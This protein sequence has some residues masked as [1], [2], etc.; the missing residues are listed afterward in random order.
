VYKRIRPLLFAVPP[1]TAH[2]TGL[3][4]ARL[5]GPTR[6][7]I[8]ASLRYDAS[9]LSQYIWGL[10]FSNPVGLAAGLD[11][12]AVAVPYWAA[13]GFGLIEIGSVS[14]RSWKGNPRPRLFRLPADRAL[15]NRM[16]LNNQGAT[17]VAGRL[18]KLPKG[19]P[20][21]GA[22]IVKTPDPTVLGD[23][24]IED[25]AESLK[26][27][28][29]TAN[30]V[31]I[32]VSCPNTLEGKTFE[33]PQALDALLATLVK[34]R[35]ETRR[36]LPLLVKLSPPVSTKFVFDSLI[37]EIVAVCMQHGIDGFVASN[38]SSS[39][40]GLA[41]RPERILTIG[42]G[43]LSGAPLEDASTHLVRYLYRKTEGLVP[44]VGVG[45]VSSPE[46]AFRKILAGASLLQLYTGLV[47]EGP[48]LVRRIKMGLS[49]LLAENGFQ[50]IRQAIGAEQRVRWRYQSP[51]SVTTATESAQSAHT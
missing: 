10:Q 43:G 37:D 40:Q 42:N 5:S 45:G 9:V 14:A 8:K 48:G 3:A 23:A 38:T 34:I 6:G 24:A 20:P 22:N 35:N 13:V 4:V 51:E 21:V 26:A 15:I 32:N 18:A 11:K 50:S 17:R 29:T 19:L 25:F 39:R 47:Y 46:T 12:N 36:H 2:N 27:V 7:L 33:D 28:I 49:Q 16:G 44:I 31:T 30:Y 1:E 41:T